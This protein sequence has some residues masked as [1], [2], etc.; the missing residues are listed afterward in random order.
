MNKYMTLLGDIVR[1]PKYAFEYIQAHKLSA[2]PAFVLLSIT[3][4]VFWTVYFNVVD[5]AWLLETTLNQSMPQASAADKAMLAEQMTPDVLK[6]S[7]LFGSQLMLLLQGLLVA[8][9]LN[10]ATKLDQENTDSF[11]DW[12][13]FYW[14]LQIPVA[15]QLLVALLVLLSS[16]DGQVTLHHLQITSLNQLLQLEPNQSLYSFAASFDFFS[17]WSFVL[18]FYGLSVKTTLKTSTVANICIIPILVMM[19]FSAFF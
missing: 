19:S 9:Y 2:W 3:L 14:W 5:M 10:I 7:S 1:R 15:F 12:Y 8:A 6:Y 18:L 16:S 4:L 11:K 17:V 13:G